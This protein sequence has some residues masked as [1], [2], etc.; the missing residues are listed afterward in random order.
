M[1]ILAGILTLF[2]A[3]TNAEIAGMISATG[4]QYV[5]FKE[6]YGKFFSYL[7]GWS[8]FA[9]VQTASIAFITYVFSEAADSFIRPHL[10][11]SAE[12]FSIHLP[13]IGAI[14]PLQNFGVKVVTVVAI[15]LLSG[16]NYIGVAF[17]GAVQTLFT[18][19]KVAALV[20]IRGACFFFRGA[21][22]RQLCNLIWLPRRRAWR[23]QGRW[24]LRCRGVLG[25]RRLAQYHDIAGEV[26]DP[27][28]ILRSLMAGMAIIIAVYLLVNLAVLVFFRW[29]QWQNPGLL[30][31][32]WLPLF[33][34][35]IPAMRRL[36]QE[37]LLS[38]S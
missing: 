34:E 24:W 23:L 25:V 3:L 36:P 4:G 12:A 22:R 26:R 35:S 20:G 1:W 11:P 14:Q 9:V 18:A 30:P 31:L 38:A 15:L 10:S 33:E 28:P 13:F 21:V 5:F 32:M 7:Y 8:M 27:Q 29:R 17:G 16:V 6:M 19:L 2:G 37:L